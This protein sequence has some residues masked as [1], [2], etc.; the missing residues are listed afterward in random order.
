MGISMH[1][2]FPETLKER[3]E[4]TKTKPNSIIPMEHWSCGDIFLGVLDSFWIKKT[5]GSFPATMRQDK[6]THPL[7]VVPSSNYGL[8]V[9]P[10][11]TSS[12][13]HPPRW[14]IP[15]GITLRNTGTTMD[16]T[17][18][19]LKMLEFPLM[20]GEEVSPAYYR[21]MLPPEELCEEK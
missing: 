16:R 19:V 10:C 11:T 12:S 5:G 4:Y 14:Y 8:R 1:Y 18:Y 20:D 15:G 17:S 13:H 21:G 3:A 9:C 7:Y 6:T 2:F